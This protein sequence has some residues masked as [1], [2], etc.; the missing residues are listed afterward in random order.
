MEADPQF[1]A[2]ITG[3]T[4]RGRIASPEEVAAAVLFLCSDGAGAMIGSPL[5]VDGGFMS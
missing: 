2:T 5:I 4:P 1:A 3:L